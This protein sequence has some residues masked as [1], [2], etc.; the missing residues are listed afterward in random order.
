MATPESDWTP[1]LQ[2]NGRVY[3]SPA[4]GFKCKKEAHDAALA[5]AT[6]LATRL[7]PEWEPHVWENCAWHYSANHKTGPMA[8]H[9]RI[10]RWEGRS[11]HEESVD[12][13][14]VYLNTNPQFI[15]RDADPMAAVHQAI[16]D[17]GSH[18]ARLQATHYAILRPIQ[19]RW[20]AAT[21]E[22]AA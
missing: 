1:R 5:A 14:T 17:L 12:K 22:R 6:A 4:C 10:R 11:E 21:A 18:I 9:P 15:A 19:E 8:V 13:Y 2:D 7:G 16:E 20:E 3:C